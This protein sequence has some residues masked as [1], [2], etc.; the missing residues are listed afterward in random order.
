M[1]GTREDPVVLSDSESDIT[2]LNVLAEED[3]SETEN[4]SETLYDSD[5]SESS[6]E[7]LPDWVGDILM[8]SDDDSV[9]SGM[10]EALDELN[11]LDPLPFPEPLPGPLPMSTG[12]LSDNA[13]VS[14]WEEVPVWAGSTC[15]HSVYCDRCHTEAKAQMNYGICPLCRQE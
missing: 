11:D 6:E 1:S 5:T 4:E 10:H 8:E 7:E 2:D 15:C 12:E 3:E 9:S 14:C 13:C